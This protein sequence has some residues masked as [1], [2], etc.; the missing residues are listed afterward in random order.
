LR[1]SISSTV[2][3][4]RSKDAECEWKKLSNPVLTSAAGSD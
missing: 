3:M 1:I 2:S 4:V